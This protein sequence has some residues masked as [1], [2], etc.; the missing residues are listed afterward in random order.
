MDK[1][2]NGPDWSSVDFKIWHLPSLRDPT[3][4]KKICQ[5]LTMASASG[6]IYRE[7][8]LETW[9]GKERKEFSTATQKM[10]KQSQQPQSPSNLL[11]QPLS[12]L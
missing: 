5:S 4:E 7:K 1:Q 12:S 2:V 11:Q 3:E 6:E 8:N 10:E 9:S